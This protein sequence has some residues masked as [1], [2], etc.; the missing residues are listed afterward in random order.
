MIRKKKRGEHLSIYYFHL[1]HDPEVRIKVMQKFVEFF[2]D[3]I[4]QYMSLIIVLC[5]MHGH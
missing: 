4:D 3:I 5:V 1:I 2:K